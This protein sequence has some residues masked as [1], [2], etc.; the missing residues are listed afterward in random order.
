MVTMVPFSVSKLR[1]PSSRAVDKKRFF[2][3]RIRA[4]GRLDF[5]YEE[6]KKGKTNTKSAERH[7]YLRNYV[8]SKAENRLASPR[9][10]NNVLCSI[11]QDERAKKTVTA[12]NLPD[13]SISNEF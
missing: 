11:A 10:A 4:N 1:F 5:I 8:W 6:G 13:M 9:E 3:Q 2:H 7:L 12:W